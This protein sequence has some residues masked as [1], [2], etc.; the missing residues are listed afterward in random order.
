MGWREASVIGIR[1]DAPN[2]IPWALQLNTS[3]GIYRV[4]GED[5]A[6]MPPGNTWLMLD[7]T[8]AG[9][10]A[11]SIGVWIG[12]LLIITNGGSSRTPDLSLAFQAPCGAL[13]SPLSYIEQTIGIGPAGGSRTNGFVLV[14]CIDGKIL[15]GWCRGD[16]AGEWPAYNLVPYPQGASYGFDLWIEG[17]IR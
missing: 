15:W 10:P 17:Y 16:G 6:G 12:S 4:F 9:V 11:D 7:V 13:P 14:P 1:D 2:A 8:Q 3:N 5:Q